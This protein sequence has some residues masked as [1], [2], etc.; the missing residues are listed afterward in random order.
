M[1]LTR[2]DTVCAH[3]RVFILYSTHHLSLATWSNS[4]WPVISPDD[5]GL[6]DIKS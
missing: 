4:T 2:P 5:P 1:I 6:P 3:E